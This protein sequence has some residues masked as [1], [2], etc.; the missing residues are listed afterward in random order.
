MAALG[1]A[2]AVHLA[3]AVAQVVGA[4]LTT[5]VGITASAMHVV[6]GAA[7][8]LVA[9]GGTWLATR[10]PDTRHPYGYDRYEAVASLLIGV[11]LLAAVA[12]IVTTAIPRIEHPEVLSASGVGIAVMGASAVANAV[13]AVF[14]GRLAGRHRS[15]V[16]RAEAVHASADFATAVAVAIGIALSAAGLLAVDPFVALTVAAIVAWRGLQTAWSA[17]EVLVDAA[18]LDLEWIR[19]LALSVEGVRDC[20]AVRS[21]GEAGRAHVDLHIH[22]AAELTVREAHGIAVRVAEVIEAQIAEVAE[23][24]VHV[25]PHLADRS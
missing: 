10:P 13:L 4:W 23:V 5:S 24:L 15:R 21:R 1:V 6:V 16:L 7:A 2:I 14:L 3:L 12:L 17:A 18:P 8:H 9:L 25:G 11:L 22:V 20:H 19:G